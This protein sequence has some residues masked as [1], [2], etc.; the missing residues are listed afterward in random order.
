MRNVTACPAA[1]ASMMIRSATP[2]ELE[3]LDLAEHE[4]VLHARDRRGHD[5][6]R[7]GTDQPLRDPAQPV[8][9]EVV[10][11][12]LVGRE[13]PGRG[14]P[15]PA[16]SPR[17]RG[18]GGRSRPRGPICPRP[19]RSARSVRRGGGSGERRGHRRLSDATLARH[20]HDPGGGAELRSSMRIHATR[21]LTSGHSPAA[22]AGRRVPRR[23]SAAILLTGVA[24]APPPGAAD[25]AGATASTWCRSTGCSTRRTRRSSATSIRRRQPARARRCSCSSST[26]ADR[27]TSTSSRCCA[28]SGARAVPVVVWVGPSGA[29]RRAPRRCSPSRRR[30]LS[31]SPGSSIGPADP[32]RLDQPG[33]TNPAR[34]AP[35]ASRRSHAVG[36]ATAPRAAAR[37]REPVGRRR[38]ARTARS[39][40]RAHRR[41]PHRLARRPDRARPRPGRCSCR[42]RRSSARVAVAAGSRTRRS[43]STAS[44][45]PTSCCTR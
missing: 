19:R 10:D 31:S 36:T 1:G 4:D 25:A 26:R 8:V 23:P 43:A 22:S 30:S 9:L 39:T 29:R 38:P 40:G 44:T 35:P 5:L 12:R 28:T 45:S 37:G 13:R 2:F 33:A 41:R 21:P 14:H 16:R 20:D 24:S 42:R 11:E 32:V 34:G 27:S 6:E 15:A 17:T 3:R 7:A 18:A